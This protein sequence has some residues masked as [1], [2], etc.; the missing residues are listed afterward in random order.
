MRFLIFGIAL[1]TLISCQSQ[2]ALINSEPATLAPSIANIKAIIGEPKATDINSCKLLEVGQKACGG[3]QRYIVYS[4]ESISNEKRLIDLVRRYNQLTLEHSQDKVST[5]E[6]VSRPEVRLV[7]G[8][9]KVH[10]A[11]P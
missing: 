7:N 5:C 6:F 10:N 4:S 8:M 2:E 1:A 3:P 9:C 11:F